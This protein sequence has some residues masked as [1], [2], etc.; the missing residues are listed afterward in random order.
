MQRPRTPGA[1]QLGRLLLLLESL[2]WLAG[3]GVLIYIGVWL[4]GAGS[5]V[6]GSGDPDYLRSFRA[7]VGAAAGVAA[8]FAFVFAVILLVP[9]LLGVWS[10][11]AI[12]KLRRSARGVGIFLAVLGILVDLGIVNGHYDNGNGDNVSAAL[13]GIVLLAV[14][15]VILYTWAFAG[16]TRA[17]FRAMRP[18]PV[19]YAAPPPGGGPVPQGYAPA[20]A[21]PQ[22]G[23]PQPQAGYPQPA[24]APPPPPPAAPDPPPPP[25]PA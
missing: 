7:T 18:A 2:M 9:S 8:T 23:Y 21:Y 24:P 5:A 4:L 17:A 12:G 25:P 16:S 14:N 1:V 13:P 3:A 11:I 22:A 10:S 19:M 20:P 15:V 6:V